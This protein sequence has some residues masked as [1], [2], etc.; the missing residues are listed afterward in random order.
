MGIFEE[1]KVY[2]NVV[3]DLKIELLLR[4]VVTIIVIQLSV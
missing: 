4:Y 1:K 3:Q 2:K